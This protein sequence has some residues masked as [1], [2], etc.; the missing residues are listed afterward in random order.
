MGL[1]QRCILQPTNG[2]DGVGVGISVTP[3]DAT[4]MVLPRECKMY[5]WLLQFCANLQI[6][7]I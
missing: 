3:L 1:G 2:R 5:V 6:P 4:V 7:S